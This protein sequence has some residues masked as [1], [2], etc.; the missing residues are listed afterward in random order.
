MPD[1]LKVAEWQENGSAARG[2]AQALPGGTELIE[3][4]ENSAPFPRS[5]A[6]LAFLPRPFA[7]FARLVLRAP[8]GALPEPRW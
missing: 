2:G 6:A 7:R 8:A 4:G 1:G 3:E 5:Y